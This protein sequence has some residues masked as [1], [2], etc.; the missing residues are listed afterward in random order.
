MWP[1][2]FPDLPP[3]SW[4]LVY[5]AM[6]R[7]TTWSSRQA[8]LEYI[9]ASPFF[10]HWHPEVMDLWASH[11]LVPIPN[12]SFTTNTPSTH[13]PNSRSE[14]TDLS[15][16]LATPSWAEACVFAEPTGLATAWDKLPHLTMPIGFIMGRHPIS[17][18]VNPDPTRE[19]VWRPPLAANEIIKSA[20]HLVSTVYSLQYHFGRC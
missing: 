11:A 6:K 18:M 3:T 17:T 13:S 1:K 10:V 4:P 14:V 9:K 8:A 12:D 5:G 19:L 15:V 16:Q 2:D 7:R 20:G